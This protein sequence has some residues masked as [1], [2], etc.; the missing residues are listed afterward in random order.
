MKIGFIGVGSMAGAILQGMLNSGVNPT[1]INIY[2]PNQAK[3]QD[4]V[5]T[6]KVN[7]YKSE[8]ECANQSDYILLGMKPNIYDSAIEKIKSALQNKITVTMAAGYEINRVEKILGNQCKVIRTMPNTPLMIGEGVTAMCKNAA[9]SDDEMNYMV[10]IF[11]KLGDV[12]VVKEDMIDLISGISGSGPTYVYMFIEALSD[13]AVL[14][15]IPRELSYQ[16]ASKTVMGAAKMVYETKQHPGVLK[17]N[18]SS[19]AG[20]TIEAI[21]SL[22]NDGF[23]G[24][25]INAVDACIEKNLKMKENK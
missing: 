6:L 19:P 2:T 24:A 23:R 9:T 15:G 20:T 25:I 1:Q 10:D 8:L 11:A 22:E 3:Q 18:V 4:L 7:G 21:K 17:D 16:L 5:N 12:H 14:R 13:G